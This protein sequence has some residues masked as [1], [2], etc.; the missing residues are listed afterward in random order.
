M[1]TSTTRW[2]QNWCWCDFDRPTHYPSYPLPIF[3]RFGG[4][5][6]SPFRHGMSWRNYTSSPSCLLVSTSFFKCNARVWR[7][8]PSVQCD[9]WHIL[10]AS[11][12]FVWM[13]CIFSSLLLTPLLGL[14]LP[15]NQIRCFTCSSILLPMGMLETRW[16]ESLLLADEQSSASVHWK[17][18]VPYEKFRYGK[19]RGQ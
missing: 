14:P 17:M 11:S 4:K 9:A 5:I 7:A 8:S 19:I 2:G 15:V 10:E 1:C 3:S 6:I 12:P 13:V 18:L 16:N